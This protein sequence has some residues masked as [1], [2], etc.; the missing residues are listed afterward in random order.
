MVPLSGSLRELENRDSALGNRGAG[1]AAADVVV[2]RKHVCE[3]VAPNVPRDGNCLWG[4]LLCRSNVGKV[5][6]HEGEAGLG[7]D[8][9]QLEDVHMSSLEDGK[10]K[11]VQDCERPVIKR[12]V[13]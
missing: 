7:A 13:G 6:S 4:R 9:P 3:F 12:N 8:M 2:L 11:G 1:T 10:K 5:M